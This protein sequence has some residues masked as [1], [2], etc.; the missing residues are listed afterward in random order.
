DWSVR[1]DTAEAV[2]GVLVN[3]AVDAAARAP[4][5]ATTYL[6][7]L[8]RSPIAEARELEM[9]GDIARA[10]LQHRD[11]AKKLYARAIDVD[12]ERISAKAEYFALLAE[13]YASR[14]SAKQELLELSRANPSAQNVLGSTLNVL[15]HNDDYPTIKALAIELLPISRCQALLWR[16]LAVA[17]QQLEDPVE[18]VLAAFESSIAIARGDESPLSFVNC[19]RPYASYLADLGDMDKAFRIIEE[20]VVA[21]PTEPNIHVVRGDLFRRVGDVKAAHICYTFAQQFAY[22]EVLG[23]INRKIT[24]VQALERIAAVLPFLAEPTSANGVG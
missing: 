23:S 22:G 13:E 2:P 17:H 8:L 12:P 7:Q 6:L 21:A 4:D 3:Q 10:R 14:Q 5:E 20:A 16:N 19:A 15:L 9:A 1:L 18:D 11:L 24:E